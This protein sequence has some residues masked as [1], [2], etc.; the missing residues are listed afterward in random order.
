MGLDHNARDV[1]RAIIQMSPLPMVLTDPLLPDDPLVFMN[2]A[3]GRLTGYREEDVLGK[4][5]RFL[6]GARTDP[7]AARAL[8][9]ARAADREAQVA[10][11]NYRKDGTAFWN[12]MFIGPVR[13]EN[14]KILYWFGSQLDATAQL[15]ADEAQARAQRMDT[16]GSMAAGIAH[17]FN[18][19]MTIALGNIE[20]MAADPLTVRQIEQLDRV[21]WAASAAS[22]LTQ[23]MLSFAGRQRLQTAEV[24]LNQV[25][26]ALDRLL[27]Q[28]RENGSY[29]EII[30]NPTL[31]PASVDVGQLELALIN[32]VWNASDACPPEGKIAVAVRRGQVR[33]AA[34][35]EIVVS[36]TCSGMPPEIAA[37]ATEPFFTTVEP[38]KGTG[39]GLSM[40][41]GFC[42]Q[43]GGDML[44]E[45]DFGNGTSIRMV[46]PEVAS[47]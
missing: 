8:K 42:R 29:V 6:Q 4:N 11:W 40:V 21:R 35:V 45:T 31:L 22:G 44:V 23:Q 47:G 41:L 12:L 33:D 7:A 43:S 20:R 5:C 14:G 26:R 19:L 2:Q 36:D 9:E 10:L 27:S 28:I 24:D 46:F 1:L 18:N 3:F 30:L 17:E 25:V 32:L 37:H 39:L 34:T 13:D 15:E 16:L 38:G